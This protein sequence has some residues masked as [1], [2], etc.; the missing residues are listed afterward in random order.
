MRK[1]LLPWGGEMGI[2]SLRCR[3]SAASGG[4][5]PAAGGGVLVTPCRC[6]AILFSSSLYHLLIGRATR[7]GPS[8]ALG[9]VFD[10]CGTGRNVQLGHSCFSV[11]SGG[12]QMM[13]YR[14]GSYS[15]CIQTPARCSA[16]YAGGPE[17]RPHSLFAVRSRVGT[18][19][20]RTWDFLLAAGIF[21]PRLGSMEFGLW[22]LRRVGREGDA[23]L[24]PGGQC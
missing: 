9:K 15:S 12:Q 1:I 7:I 19:S 6:R 8:R 20:M 21:R 14:T 17:I 3:V 22:G 5:S 13:V 2:I 16:G 24:V 11:R 4:A 18:R 10:L 23:F